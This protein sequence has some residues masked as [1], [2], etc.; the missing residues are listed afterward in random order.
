MLSG[1]LSSKVVVPVEFAGV[2]GRLDQLTVEVVVKRFGLLRA[3]VV[4]Q[5][6][7][8]ADS[9]H[10]VKRNGRGEYVVDHF[11]EQSIERI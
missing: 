2:V 5:N 8:V 3:A 10:R 6:G 9:S 11:G 4:I 1:E 7:A